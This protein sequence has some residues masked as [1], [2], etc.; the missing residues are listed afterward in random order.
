MGASGVRVVVQAGISRQVFRAVKPEAA[1]ATAVRPDGNEEQ[2]PELKHAAAFG[3]VD[4]RASAAGAYPVRHVNEKT[5][6]TPH[7]VGIVP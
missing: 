5:K 4:V 7:G 3:A 6:D 1:F 2:H